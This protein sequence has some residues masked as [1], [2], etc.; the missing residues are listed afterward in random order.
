MYSSAWGKMQVS[1]FFSKGS[2]K[3]LLKQQVPTS[4]FS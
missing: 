3:E 2:K 4:T 1:E